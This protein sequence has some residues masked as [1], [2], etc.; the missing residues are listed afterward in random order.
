MG[1]RLRALYLLWAQFNLLERIIICVFTAHCM[2]VVALYLQAAPVLARSASRPKVTVQTITLHPKP[3][4]VPT[5]PQALAEAPK[6]KPTP[7]PQ[8]KPAPKP[9]PQ[10]KAPA[11]P[12][13]APPAP[14][15]TAPD[16]KL[17]EAAKK[18]REQLDKAKRKPAPQAPVLTKAP[19]APPSR[20]QLRS[21]RDY[22]EKLSAHLQQMLCLPDYGEVQIEVIVDR[23]GKLQGW[24]LVSARSSVNR[25]YV[26]A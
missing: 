17:A 16:P 23:F 5:P 11:K 19:P 26:K 14:A 1:K 12:K 9:K 10:A 24:E 4:P 7:V 8:A 18:I 6:P 21:N 13:K 20:A 22:E 15:A 25:D 3:A 2:C